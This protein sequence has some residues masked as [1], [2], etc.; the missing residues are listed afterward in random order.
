VAQGEAHNQPKHQ[1][2]LATEQQTWPNLNTATYTSQTRATQAAHQVQTIVTDD[3]S[4]NLSI[5]WLTPAV[6]AGYAGSLGAVFAKSLW[7]LVTKLSELKKQQ[8]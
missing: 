7:P 6:H 5:A 2:V 3:R 4:V 8:L 1:P